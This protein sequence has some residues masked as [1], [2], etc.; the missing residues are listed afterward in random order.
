M[1]M[2]TCMD[3]TRLPASI[4]ITR[5]RPDLEPQQLVET[6]RQE[7]FLPPE[8][9][10]LP[11]LIQMLDHNTGNA[12]LDVGEMS[13]AEG[14]GYPEWS[15]EN[16]EWL[17]EEWR[18][19]RP[20]LDGV[21]ALLNWKNENDEAVAEKLSAVRDA[22]VTAHKRRQRNDP[23]APPRL[24]LDFY[25]TAVLM[26][27]WEEDGRIIAHPVS[28]HDVV[29][30]CTNIALGSGLLPPNTLFWKQQA[31]PAGDRHLRPGAPLADAG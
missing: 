29:S 18:Q 25:P 21:L 1:Q 2:I 16:V 28:V 19:A 10:A 9:A 24:R 26:S 5:C 11:D 20:V 17:A 14:G 8:L 6:L 12:W 7:S 31:R 13:L 27:R 3:A 22:L 23:A 15:R 30:A 4:P